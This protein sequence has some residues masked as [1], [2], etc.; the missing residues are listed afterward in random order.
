MPASRRKASKKKTKSKRVTRRG[1]TSYRRKSS[2]KSD[3]RPRKK[4]SAKKDDVTYLYECTRPGCGYKIVRDEKAE[5]GQL[6]SD[7]KCP[8]CHHVEFRCLGKGDLPES[9]QVPIP[10]NPVNF[11][12]VRASEIGSN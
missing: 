10:S 7:L 6:R 9:F 1:K 12:A 8:K 4:T 2:P 3:S 5:P 11:D